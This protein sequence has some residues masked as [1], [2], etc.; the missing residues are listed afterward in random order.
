[1]AWTDH[2]YNIFTVGG[3]TYRFAPMELVYVGDNSREANQIV[4]EAESGAIKIVTVDTNERQLFE[5][6]LHEMPESDYTIA[7]ATIRGYNS[8]RGM[9]VGGA[10]NQMDYHVTTGTLS[11]EGDSAGATTTVRY[12]ST[13]FDMHAATFVVGDGAGAER[14]YGD[15]SQILVFRKEIT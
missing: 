5:F 13:T 6:T 1:M 15:G 2:D 4:Q 8:L 14:R 10:S 3:T 9:L 7:G 11:V 12:W